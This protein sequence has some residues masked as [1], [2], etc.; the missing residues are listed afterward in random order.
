MASE[1]LL[2]IGATATTSP[3]FNIAMG[4]EALVSILTETAI[5]T[6]VAITFERQDI[7]G[8]WVKHSEGGFFQLGG[9]VTHRIIRR[10]GTYRAVR[11][12][13]TPFDWACGV[14]IDV[15]S[16]TCINTVVPF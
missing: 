16:D 7:L 11:P 4:E 13:T 10:P 15:H 6:G 9:T 3:T 1:I 8:N 5:P 12:D 14:E 2:D